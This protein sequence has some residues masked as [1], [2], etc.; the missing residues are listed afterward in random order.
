MK[1]KEYQEIESRYSVLF[2][3]LSDIRKEERK[4]CVDALIKLGT[5]DIENET[6][7]KDFSHNRVSVRGKVLDTAEPQELFVESIFL[8]RNILT[9]VVHPKDYDDWSMTIHPEHLFTGELINIIPYI[10]DK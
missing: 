5:H 2:D 8:F 6:Y 3:K 10:A 4:L 9:M 1:I 7:R